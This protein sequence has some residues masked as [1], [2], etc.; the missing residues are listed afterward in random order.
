MEGP[1]TLHAG[2]PSTR[3]GS[4]TTVAPHTYI[5]RRRYDDDMQPDA[6]RHVHADEGAEAVWLP[7][8]AHSDVGR[9]QRGWYPLAD[10][11]RCRRFDRAASAGDGFECP[12]RGDSRGD[13]SQARESSSGAIARRWS[14]P[15]V[16]R[17]AGYVGSRGDEDSLLRTTCQLGTAVEEAD[18]TS[19]EQSMGRRG[20]GP[21][22]RSRR[23]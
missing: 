8:P 23:P 4:S 5:E 3:G 12:R 9:L 7:A 2:R 22:T 14:S 1:P 20:S 21:C 11:R 18:F 15:L 6:V 19:A 10:R 13:C 16:G 17:R